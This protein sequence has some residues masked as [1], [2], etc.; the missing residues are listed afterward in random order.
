MRFTP[1]IVAILN[2]TRDSFSDGGRFLAP[3][4]A[5]AHADALAEAGADW[6][7]LGPASSNPDAAR[8]APEAQIAR[9]AP[10]L[11][12]IG[13]RGLSISVDA[14]ES[15]VLEFALDSGSVDMLNDIRGFPD[16]RLYGRLADTNA[17]LVVVHSLLE[18]DRA[19]RDEASP[20]AV[21][22]SIERFFDARLRAL[23][24]AGIAESRLIVDPGMGF[25]LGSDPRASTAVLKRIPSLRER[26][27]RPVL[28]SVSRKSFLRAITG[29]GVDEIGAATLA[30][31]LE[32]ARL[33]ADY[34]RTHDP[35]ALRDALRVLN[36]LDL[37]R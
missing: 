13:D 19:T 20:D 1:E 36:A 24:T 9:L 15:R 35:G 8:V 12:A 7:E 26:F 37:E 21:L 22:E 5:I 4:A 27:G 3:E 11:D 6:I 16:T 34:L 30:A 33:G 23:V 31:E 18:R 14:T 28:V 25:F 10:V 32:A 2:I 29:R 17:R